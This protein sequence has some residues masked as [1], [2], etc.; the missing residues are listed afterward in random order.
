MPKRRMKI[1]AKMMTKKTEV[2]RVD[3]EREADETV[4][5]YKEHA[6]N[7]GYTVVKTKVDYKSKKDRK[8]HEI[9]EEYWLVEVTVAY[10]L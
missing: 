9:S 10:E 2:Y 3:S 7:E 8:T 5:W 1:M 4:D 6:M